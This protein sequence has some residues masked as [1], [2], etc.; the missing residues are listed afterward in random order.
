MPDR[1]VITQKPHWCMLLDSWGLSSLLLASL[2]Q[3]AESSSQPSGPWPHTSPS[4]WPSE[5]S[6]TG[7]G[8]G[9]GREGGVY[10]C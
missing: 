8:G 2:S 4:C 9:G 10:G 6:H 7:G 1:G 3:R 5:R